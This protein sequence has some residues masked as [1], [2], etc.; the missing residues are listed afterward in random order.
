MQRWPVSFWRR[1]KRETELNEEVRS[2]LEMAARERVEKGEEKEEAECAARREFGNV[3]LVKEVTRD[4]WGWRWLR[5]LADDTR[6]GVRMLLKNPGFT[7]IAVLSLALGI[8]ANTAI[9]QLLNAVRL[10]TLPVKAPQE[11][12]EVRIADMKGARG[13]FN[14]QYPPVTNPIWEKI[15]ERQQ[16]FSGILAWGK[17]EF[18]LSQGGEVHTAKGLWVSGDFFT[19]LG[20]QPVLRLLFT[21]SDDT[22]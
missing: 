12:A 22:R 16:A 13:A 21:A 10:K 11:L 2:H 4:I 7:A 15:R 19:V 5:D 18:N 8:G 6:Y 14:T 9:F 1:K 3:G 20:V 17:R